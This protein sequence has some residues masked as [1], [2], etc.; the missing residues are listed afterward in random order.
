MTEQEWLTYTN[1]YEMLYYLWKPRTSYRKPHL[2]NCAFCRRIWDVF[3]DE[4]S[5]RAVEVGERVADGLASERE[6]HDA[7]IAA[8]D[9][10][11][12]SLSTW[13]GPQPRLWNHSQGLD[14]IGPDPHDPECYAEC[15]IA[16]AA[17]AAACK[18]VKFPPRWGFDTALDP[19]LDAVA[20][21]VEKWEDSDARQE[22]IAAEMK[23]QC[24]LVRDIVGNPFR[25]VSLDPAW[26]RPDVITLAGHIY[27][28]RAFDEM[29]ALADALQDAGCSNVEVLSHCRRQPG[30]HVLGC[31]LVDLTLG[32]S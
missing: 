29:P 15:F 13:R 9:A 4:R 6:I 26:L 5:R 14:C 22:A 3:R 12:E 1:T 32:K 8:G 16:D 27:H 18:T 11:M 20:D 2:L 7:V 10:E 30:G 31:W 21:N 28:D 17:A 24:E 23:V 19:I 25:P